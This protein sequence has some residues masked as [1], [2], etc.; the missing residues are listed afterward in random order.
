[1]YG[2]GTEVSPNTGRMHTVIRARGGLVASFPHPDDGIAEIVG[3]AI[4]AGNDYYLD[5]N[6]DNNR[7]GRAFTS[8]VSTFTKALSLMTSGRGD[9]L[10]VRPGDY[11]ESEINVNVA[12]AQIIGMG[13]NGAVG[14]TPASGIEAMKITA[15]DVV[16]RNLRVEGVNDAD[17]GLSIGDADNSP[18][19][20]RVAGC[21]LR[22]GSHAT[23]PAVILHGP[24]DLYLVGCDIAWAGIGIQF[25]GNLAG[26]PTQIFTLGNY[27][28]NLSVQHLA[29]FQTSGGS[30]NGKVVNLNHISNKHDNLEDGTEPTGV[31]IELDHTGSSG[32]IE[33]NSFAVASNAIAK[34]A[35]ATNIHWVANKTEAGVSS[36][37]PA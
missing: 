35:I 17:Y 27:F 33:D 9:R 25:K 3:L 24:G 8:A 34:F 11:A 30:D 19:G 10:F 18:L 15:N 1:M 31:F 14:I 5:A 22:N 2:V 21:L 13:A 16:L 6:G 36:A 26:Y 7:S 23:K 29:Q 28:H 20:V 32:L 12:D 37:R 4:P